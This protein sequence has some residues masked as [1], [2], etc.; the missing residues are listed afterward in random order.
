M[1]QYQVRHG[2]NFFLPVS[3]LPKGAKLV[4][5]GN[6]LVVAHSETGHHHVMT[7]PSVKDAVIK[8][9]EFEGQTYLDVPLEAKLQHQKTTEAHPMR[10]LQPG[11]YRKLVQSTFNYADKAMRKVID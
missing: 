7:I 8:I 1:K 2:E 9:F 10:I 11:F 6:N 5:E 3:E 4:E